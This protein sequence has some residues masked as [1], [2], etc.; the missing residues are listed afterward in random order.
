MTTTKLTI[1]IIALLAVPITSHAQF[2]SKITKVGTTVAQFLKIDV[3]GRA[4]GMGGAF[5]AAANDATS[6]Y[7]NPAGIAGS[8]RSEVH[9]MHADWLA[10]TNFDFAG[11][12]LPLGAFGTLGASVTSLSMPEMEVRT[13]FYPEGT[14][15]RFG[16]GD[17][18]TGVSY[19]RMLTDRFAIGFTAKYIRQHIWDMSASSV[20]L[21]FGTLFTTGFHGMRLG[22]S[23]SNF[24]NKMRY[25]GKNTRVFYDQNPWEFGDN[26]KLPAHLQTDKWSLPLLFR[27]GIAMPVFD[28]EVNRLLIAADAIHPNDDNENVNLGAEYAFKKWLFLR[29][30]FKALGSRDSEEGLTF[31]AGFDSA[32]IGSTNLR[33]DYAWADW[34]RLSSVHRFSLAL[35]F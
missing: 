1:P 27:V 29:A 16:A 19:A 32:I 34:G 25:E 7:W 18:A 6:L 24:G 31:G 2:S 10:D 4:I 11:V 30:G 20:A 8:E 15:E 12:V 22:M 35:R 9:L 26:D 17:V 5:V 13:V 14:G 28:S 3:G 33:V 23:I 21:D